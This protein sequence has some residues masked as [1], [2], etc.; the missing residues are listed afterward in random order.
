MTIFNKNPIESEQFIH[1]H[2]DLSSKTV[3]FSGKI[4]K[5]KRMISLDLN[6]VFVTYCNYEYF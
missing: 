6:Y 5:E 2:F 1:S 4:N 3:E